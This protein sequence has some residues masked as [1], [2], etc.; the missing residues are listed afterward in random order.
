MICDKVIPGNDILGMYDLCFDQPEIDQRKSLVDSHLAAYVPKKMRLAIRPFQ[1]SVS[2]RNQWPKN[3][4]GDLQG[5]R[6]KIWDNY[7]D[8]DTDDKASI[9]SYFFRCSFK[10]PSFSL[11]SPPVKR[12][13]NLSK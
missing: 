3:S 1:K 13:H 4:Q 10:R 9:L 8:F 11:L 12:I 2:F 5:C 7:P 6:E